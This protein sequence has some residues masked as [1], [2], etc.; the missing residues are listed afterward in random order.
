MKTRDVPTD[1]A[2]ETAPPSLDQLLTQMEL[3]GA[4]RFDRAGR[5]LSCSATMAQLIGTPSEEIV[6]STL[7]EVLDAPDAAALLALVRGGGTHVASRVHV[8]FRSRARRTLILECA[9]ALDSGGGGL[10]G[11]RPRPV[12]DATAFAARASSGGRR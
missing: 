2:I 7:G 1:A 11:S 12:L 9:V 5:I 6:A 4:L 3:L 8:A 10:L